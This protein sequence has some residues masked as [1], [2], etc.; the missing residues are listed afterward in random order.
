MVH[1]H[2]T[3]KKKNKKKKGLK[4]HKYVLQ[5]WFKQTSAASYRSPGYW[6][7]LN[8]NANNVPGNVATGFWKWGKYMR[9]DLSLM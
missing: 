7:S 5:N 3:Y 8:D 1:K 6:T 2:V 9:T 4:I